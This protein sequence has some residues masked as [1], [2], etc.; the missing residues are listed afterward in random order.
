[1]DGAIQSLNKWNLSSSLGKADFL[2]EQV[3]FKT[4]LP[5]EQGSSQDIL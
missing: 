3:T 5:N 1:M 2:A 4:F